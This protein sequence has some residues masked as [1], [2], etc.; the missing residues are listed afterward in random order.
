MPHR[1]P[2]KSLV[3]IGRVLAANGDT[4]KSLRM[5]LNEIQLVLLSSR[6]FSAFKKKKL[7]FAKTQI[8]RKAIGLVWFCQKSQ[9]RFLLLLPFEKLLRHPA[10]IVFRPAAIQDL[11]FFLQ[12]CFSER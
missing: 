10:E 8:P 5:V 11:S 4:L 6:C 2:R 1:T 12:W 7:F 9:K 3:L